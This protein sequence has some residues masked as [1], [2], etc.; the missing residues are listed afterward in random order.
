MK[1][2]QNVKYLDY[3]L[4]K[5]VNLIR[6]RVKDMC[7]SVCVCERERE[8]VGEREREMNENLCVKERGLQER[9]VK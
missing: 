4:E 1:T 2:S 3:M 6:R 9:K 5:S 7:V 8:R